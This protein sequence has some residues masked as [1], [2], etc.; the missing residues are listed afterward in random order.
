MAFDIERQIETISKAEAL[1]GKLASQFLE[2]KLMHSVLQ[3]EKKTIEHA[4]LI[5]EATN[6]GI[7]SF[8]PDILFDK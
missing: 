3:A 6:R 7:G 1:D 5:H 2:D 8:T 4:E